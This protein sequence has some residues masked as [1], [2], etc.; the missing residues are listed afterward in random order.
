M[1]FPYPN[2]KAYLIL[3]KQKPK[4]GKYMTRKGKRRL[5]KSLVKRKKDRLTRAFRNIFVMSGY[6]EE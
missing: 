5:K 3:K 2:K 1:N 4:R 6:L